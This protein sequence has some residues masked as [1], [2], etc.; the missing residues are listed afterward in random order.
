[1]VANFEDNVKVK[2]NSERHLEAEGNPWPTAH[3]KT[4]T[5]VLQLQEA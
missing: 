2:R 3:K 5:S 4:A 1:M